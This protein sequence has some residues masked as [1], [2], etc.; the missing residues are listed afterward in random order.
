MTVLISCNQQFFQSFFVHKLL[1]CRIIYLFVMRKV[2]LI[3]AVIFA[4]I[5]IL[6][7]ILP[8]GTIAFLPLG[9]AVILSI[10]A[11]VKSVDK[12]KNFPK[13][14][15]IVSIVAVLVVAGKQLF[16][17]DKVAVDQQFKNEKIEKQQEAKKDLEGLE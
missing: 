3:L 15:L 13:W 2:L 11:I 12:Q 1:F 7:T 8:L 14:V 5:G 17:K 16:I 9:V 4:V 6:F 10:L